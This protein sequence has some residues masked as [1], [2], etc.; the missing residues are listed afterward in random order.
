MPSMRVKTVILYDKTKIQPETIDRMAAAR[1][2]EFIPMN[3]EEFYGIM[4]LHLFQPEIDK[5]LK[6]DAKARP[7]SAK[8]G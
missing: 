2:G 3:R 6:K 5:V 1:D 4:E 7:R 8:K